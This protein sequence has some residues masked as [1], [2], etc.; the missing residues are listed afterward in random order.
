MSALGSGYYFFI[1]DSLRANDQRKADEWRGC[2]RTRCR[3]RPAA[4]ESLTARI[5]TR[6]PVI[7]RVVAGRA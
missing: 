3:S 2:R 7:R 4:P 6:L 5:A 1:D